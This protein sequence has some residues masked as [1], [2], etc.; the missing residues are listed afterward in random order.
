MRTER[1]R[2]MEDYIYEKGTVSLVE[3]CETFGVSINTIRRDVDQI[4]ANTDIKQ[5]YGGVTVDTS[6][7]RDIVSFEDRNVSNAD[8]K[9]KIAEKAASFIEDGDIIYIDGR[10]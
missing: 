10:L 2:D 5:S 1:L 7:R 8:A 3:L 9:N 6:Y 4:V